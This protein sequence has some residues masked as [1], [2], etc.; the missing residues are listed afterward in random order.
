MLKWTAV[1][2]IDMLRQVLSTMLRILTDPERGTLT[3]AKAVRDRLIS[4]TFRADNHVDVVVT[5]S[6][7]LH[8]APFQV[9]ARGDIIEVESVLKMLRDCMPFRKAGTLRYRQFVAQ[10][11]NDRVIALVRKETVPNCLPKAAK[12]KVYVVLIVEWQFVWDTGTGN[13]TLEF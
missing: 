7:L 10:G 6:C 1:T 2:S 12:R 13:G 9:L 3:E 11:F 4:K 8:V 5:S